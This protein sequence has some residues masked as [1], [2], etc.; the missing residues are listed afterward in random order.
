MI[1]RMVHRAYKDKAAKVAT[2]HQAESAF[3]AAA[4]QKN[5]SNTLRQDHCLLAATEKPMKWASTGTQVPGGRAAKAMPTLGVIV[6][7]GTNAHVLG[8]VATKSVRFAQTVRLSKR[9][10]LPLPAR[11]EEDKGDTPEP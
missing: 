7:A 10:G 6:G 11:L 8:D 1:D 4:G 9:Q 5:W 3:A 2:Q